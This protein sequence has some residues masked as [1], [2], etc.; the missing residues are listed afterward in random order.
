MNSSF[1]YHA[2]DL[3]DHKCSRIEYKGNTIILHVETNTINVINGEEAYYTNVWV[4]YNY[5]PVK[6]TS[7][8]ADTDAPDFGEDTIN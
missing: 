5:E 4:G 8:S 3:C 6:F 2:W 1:L 7:F